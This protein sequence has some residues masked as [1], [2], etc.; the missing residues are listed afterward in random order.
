MSLSVPRS[1][2]IRAA[3]ESLVQLQSG[4]S[5]VPTSVGSTSRTKERQS[6]MIVVGFIIGVIFGLGISMYLIKT[7]DEEW[8]K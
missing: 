8:K 3:M 7:N 4:A 5:V 6:N 1:W 2:A